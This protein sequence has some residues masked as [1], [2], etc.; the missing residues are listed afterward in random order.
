VPP[1]VI[2]RLVRKLD[3]P[4]PWEA[5]E[6]IRVTPGLPAWK[7]EADAQQVIRKAP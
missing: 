7:S 3:P 2:D 5:H 4:R 1:A 6:I